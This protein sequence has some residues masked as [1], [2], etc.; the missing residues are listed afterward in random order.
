MLW[1]FITVIV[2]HEVEDSTEGKVITTFKFLAPMKP[3]AAKNLIIRRDDT[4]KKVPFEYKWVTAN[5]LRVLISEKEFPRGL[6]YSYSFRAAPVMIWPLHVWASGSFSSNVQLRFLGVKN[7][8]AVPSGGPIL[9]QFNTFVDPKEIQKYIHFPVSGKIEPLQ[10][11]IEK[12]Q[13]YTDYSQWQY[14]PSKKLK[15]QYNYSISIDKG[16][17][18][19]NGNPLQTSVKTNFNTTAEFL[20]TQVYPRPG[21]QSVWLT[22]EIILETNQK[23]KSC[24][25]SIEGLQGEPKIIDQRVLFKSDRVMMPGKTYNVKA[26]LISA[27][28]EKLDY[29]YSFSTT[30]LGNNQWLELKL[31]QVPNLWVVAGNKT[32]RKINVSIKSKPE[33][34]KGTLYEQNRNVTTN[35]SPCWIRLNADILLHTVPENTKDDHRLLN[36][37]TTYSC[38]YLDN[39]DLTDLSKTLPKG[40]ML[41]CH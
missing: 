30:N 9:L 1:L 33:I 35:N 12:N 13:L 37:P 6:K 39:K 4:G 20:I 16:L 18:G 24:K 2:T 34:P 22:R 5:T 10:I 3:A 41:I 38:I 14:L 25:I 8:E 21:S 19:L 17:T 7:K 36:L 32:I 40:F 28:N 26:H 23:L 29:E 31:G 15:N 27:S 11:K